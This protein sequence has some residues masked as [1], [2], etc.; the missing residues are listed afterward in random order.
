MESCDIIVDVRA[1]MKGAPRNGEMRYSGGVGGGRVKRSPS[2]GSLL[3]AVLVRVVRALVGHTE[4]VS[5][6]CWMRRRSSLLL[7]PASV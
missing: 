6:F 5:T 7:I 4:I 3:L 2:N 1:A